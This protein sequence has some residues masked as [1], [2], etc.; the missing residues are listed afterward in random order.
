MLCVLILYVSSGTYSLKSTLNDRFCEKLFMA[1]LFTK[2]MS[3]VNLLTNVQ[4]FKGHIGYQISLTTEIL[5][6][7]VVAVV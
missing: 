7:S 2:Y 6:I 4:T 3:A 1:I 5:S